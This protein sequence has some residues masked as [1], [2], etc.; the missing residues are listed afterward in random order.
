MLYI[1]LGLGFTGLC[2][3]GDEPPEESDALTITSRAEY[4]S[5]DLLLKEE[6]K[7]PVTDKERDLDKQ[8]SRLG[9]GETTLLTLTGKEALIGDLSKPQW[10]IRKAQKL[11]VIEP[12]KGTAAA[13]LIINNDLTQPKDEQG[14][15]NK[16]EITVCVT[17]SAGGYK[18][19]S[20]EIVYPSA[21]TGRH[22]KVG[23]TTGAIVTNPEYRMSKDGDTDNAGASAELEVI[24]GPTDVSFRKISIREKDQG[25]ANNH[26]PS[27]STIHKIRE[28]RYSPKAKNIITDQIGSFRP[29][30]EIERDK[31][32]LDQHWEWICAWNTCDDHGNARHLITT[33]NQSFDYKRLNTA[34]QGQAVEVILNKFGCTV[35]RNTQPGNKHS[36]TPP[37]P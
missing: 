36:F 8:R 10:S 26:K 17:T 3:A 33:V 23:N 7:E 30:A 4:Y 35:Q 14:Q 34:R 5:A 2:T 37:R 31:H 13:T 25:F 28:E 16:Q 21:M 19:I 22:T 27:L 1:T 11:A 6:R 9:I 29:L 24:I 18:T 20:F 12:L 15:I 32:A